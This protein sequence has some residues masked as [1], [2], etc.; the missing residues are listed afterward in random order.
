[1]PSPGL[2]RGARM[3]RRCRRSS[4]VGA[5]HPWRRFATRI[6]FVPLFVVLLALYYVG[7]FGA[8]LSDLEYWTEDFADEW[9]DWVESPREIDLHRRVLKRFL[10][11]TI[12]EA[13]NA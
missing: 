4:R 3:L 9:K 11:K 1:M 8:W 10:R 12:T 2:A 7:K 5:I 6:L 13:A